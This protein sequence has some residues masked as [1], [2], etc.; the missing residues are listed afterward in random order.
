ML[1]L[2]LIVLYGDAYMQFFRWRTTLDLSRLS[3]YDLCYKILRG[4]F[5]NVPSLSQSQKAELYYQA[6]QTGFTFIVY[7]R[8]K[9]PLG[10]DISKDRIDITDASPE[11]QLLLQ[12]A[13]ED[14]PMVSRRRTSVGRASPKF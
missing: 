6:K 8:H 7:G 14:T 2:A 5:P 9:F 4:Q 3:R 12:Q 10:F 11:T 1:E 13:V